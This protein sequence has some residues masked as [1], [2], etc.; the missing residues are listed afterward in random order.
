M[1]SHERLLILLVGDFNIL[2]HTHEKNKENFNGRW[3]FLFNY[4]I[5]G[6]NL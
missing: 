1:M 2:R 6:L 4:V 5:D 3:S